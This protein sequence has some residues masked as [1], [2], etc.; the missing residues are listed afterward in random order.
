VACG[1]AFAYQALTS[2]PRLLA[3]VHSPPDR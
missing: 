3:L 2:V 1:V